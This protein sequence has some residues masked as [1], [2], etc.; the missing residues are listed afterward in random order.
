MAAEYDL[1]VECMGDISDDLK[2][3]MKKLEEFACERLVTRMERV[4]DR[5]GWT[6]ERLGE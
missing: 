1:V 3:P 5:L 6:A 4:L 2:G